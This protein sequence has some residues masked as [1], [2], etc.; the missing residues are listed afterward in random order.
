MIN[1]VTR[2]WSLA[3]MC[4]F[5]NM[6]EA[7]KDQFISSCGL[8]KLRQKFIRETVTSLEKHAERAR[9]VKCQKSKR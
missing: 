7:V 1:F 5:L 9:N 3:E 6:S 8:K 2:L 4:N